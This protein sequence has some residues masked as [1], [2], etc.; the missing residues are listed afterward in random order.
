MGSFLL[1]VVALLFMPLAMSLPAVLLILD[2]YPLR[3]FPDEAGRWFG[4]SARRAF[5]EKVP[6][7]MTSFL[8]MRLAIAA[9]P[10]SQVPVDRQG[11]SAGIARA[12]YAIWLYIG[13][14]VIPLDLIPVYPLPAKVSWLALPYSLCILAT[15]AISVGL[16][17]LRRR[18]PGL[19]AA[20]LSYLVILAPNSGIVRINDQ[21]AADRYTNMATLGWVMVA[22]AG[23]S[24][25]WRMSWRWHPGVRIGIIALGLGALLGL[26]A[27]TRNQCRV[28]FNSETLWAHDLTHG[29]DSSFLPHNNFGM[30]LC[31]QG[32]Y[33]AAEAHFTEALRLN[34]DCADAH[35]NLAMLLL[36]QGTYP[37]AEAHLA[38]AIRINPGD[39]GAH[40]HLGNLLYAQG[41]FEKAATH[42]TEALWGTLG[43]AD[44]HRNLGNIL[45]KQ[46]RYEEAETHLTEALRLNPD[47]TD[48]H[49]N[50]A[51]ILFRGKRYAEAEA[52][53]TEA[54][55]LNPGSTDIHNNLGTVLSR[56]KRYAEAEAHFTEALL[57]DPG[58]VA[59]HFNLG[60]VHAEQG[61]DEAAV[62]H[63]AEAV[64]RHPGYVG[65]HHNLGNVLCRL[66]K[67]DAAAAQYAEAI[68]LDPGYAEAYNASA[69]LM[70]ACPEAKFRE[71]KKA[72]QFATRACELTKGKEPRFFNTL[73]AAQAESGDFDAAVKSQVRA[74]ELLA[75]ERQKDDYR[76]RLMLYQARR[77]YRAASPRRE[78]SA[79]SP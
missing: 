56:Q 38:E 31:A 59:A 41:K 68:R 49:I 18:W 8:F 36:R 57:L 12:C 20:W 23:F 29:G 28:W 72:V 19:L 4:A 9:R 70:A 46:G 24:R 15:L 75:D 2:V 55:R 66:G 43:D 45:Y 47:F 42:L 61:K 53:F 62:A 54:L 67:Y 1:F 40:K 33:K 52:H 74:I 51:M 14:T 50:L 10:A 26:T 34:A 3:R 58:F 44:V 13:K 35:N 39:A 63:Y 78:P 64:R 76:S 30:V 69:M 48:A 21:I 77:P 7:V 5:L 65:A 60:L 71:G 79:A 37:E 22:A 32:K 11:A 16:F 27:L 17:L 25:I 73:A 6:F